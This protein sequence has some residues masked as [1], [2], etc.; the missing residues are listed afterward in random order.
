[1]IT[2]ATLGAIVASSHEGSRRLAIDLL[3]IA[4]ECAGLAMVPHEG[5]APRAA[6]VLR[7]LDAIDDIEDLA[8]RR[9]GARL[10]LRC[11]R[12][13]LMLRAMV[14]RGRPVVHDRRS[15]Y[16]ADDE[17]GGEPQAWPVGPREAANDNA[18]AERKTAP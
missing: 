10:P 12:A 8:T 18:T 5:E 4:C 14:A 16:L 7:A 17:T 13:C 9:M 15:H 6:R 3:A 1:M 11:W 2:T